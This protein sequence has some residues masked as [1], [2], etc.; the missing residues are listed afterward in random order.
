MSFCAARLARALNER[1]MLVSWTETETDKVSYEVQGASGNTYTVVLSK[2]AAECSCRDWTI[3][4]VICKHVFYVVFRFLRARVPA[5]TLPGSLSTI[6]LVPQTTVPRTCESD[7]L[8]RVWEP[9]RGAWAEPR[10][11]PGDECA[12]CFEAMDPE[13]E[14]VYW[15]RFQCG[16]CVHRRCATGLRG[17]CPHCR[18]PW[19]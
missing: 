10:W 15:C 17:T 16:K 7:K 8:R 13:S 12:I 2:T 5:T 3:R 1:M 14:Y 18:A 4:G 6:S 19:R 11:E 9:H